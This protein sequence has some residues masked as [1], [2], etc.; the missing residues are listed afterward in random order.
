ML[1]N[2]KTSKQTKLLVTEVYCTLPAQ[3]VF[4]LPSGLA[5]TKTSVVPGELSLESEIRFDCKFDTNEGYSQVSFQHTHDD[6][7]W[8]FFKRILS[9]EIK[10]FIIST[11]ESERFAQYKPLGYASQKGSHSVVGAE[12]EDTT[13]NAA[14][15]SYHSRDH[16]FNQGI[17]AWEPVNTITLQ[18]HLQTV[19]TLKDWSAAE[20]IF[21]Q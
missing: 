2:N 7:C 6:H 13:T 19:I 1:K 21:S 3:A 9:G 11:W 20:L 16:F 14:K 4:Y 5:E 15:Q 18:S 12:E 10:L 17:T 8:H